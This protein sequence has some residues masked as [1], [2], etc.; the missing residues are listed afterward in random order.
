MQH[1]D[2]ITLNIENSELFSPFKIDEIFLNSNCLCTSSSS[3]P[4]FIIEFHGISKDKLYHLALCENCRKRK[5]IEDI[6][7]SENAINFLNE[8]L[9]KYHYLNPLL[10]SEL[11]H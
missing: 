3:I 5:T 6:T 9:I 1:L 7:D 8:C 11:E 2:I 4:I 10:E